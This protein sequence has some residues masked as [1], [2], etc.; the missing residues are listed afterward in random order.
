M[1]LDG[2]RRRGGVPQPR[3]ASGFRLRP[4]EAVEGSCACGIR[5]ARIGTMK[6]M[7]DVKPEPRA[8]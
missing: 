8:D 3:D 7:K 6:S 5:R 1:R 2:A 4:S